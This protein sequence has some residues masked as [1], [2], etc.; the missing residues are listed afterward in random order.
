MKQGGIPRPVLVSR[1]VARE[2]G[3]MTTPFPWPLAAVLSDE[4]ARF[5]QS[6]DRAAALGYTHIE[7]PALGER[8]LAHLEALADAGVIVACAVLSGDL[9]RGSG[10]IRREVLR[11]LERQ[12]ADAARLGATC[13]ILSAGAE[14]Q[15][16]GE[17]YFTEGCALLA[18]YAAGRMVRLAVRPQAGSCLADA[19]A[20]LA[21][22]ARQSVE[23]VGLSLEESSQELLRQAG[24]RLFHLRLGTQSTATALAEV[25]AE[26]D[27]RGVVGVLEWDV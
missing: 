2:D 14:P 15:P 18:E 19:P 7:I 27:D 26:I 4:P 16:S 10:A 20:V 24:R 9:S 5:P 3:A 12:V 11:Q 1:L 23:G 21:W 17:A 8:P 25:L 22:L 6:V 13:A